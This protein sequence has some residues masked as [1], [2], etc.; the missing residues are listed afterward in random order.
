MVLCIMSVASLEFI[1]NGMLNFAAS[2]VMGGV[3]AAP[4]E[5]SYAAMAYAITAVLALFNHRWCAQQLGSR[6]LVQVS[7]LL[8]AIG[9]VQ[10]AVANTPMAFI[11]GRAL[12]G[13]GGA[14]FF[15][16][17]R[18][19]V[20]T[21]DAKKRLIALLFFGYS[22][23]LGSALGPWLGSLLLLHADWRWIF[24]GILPWIAVAALASSRLHNEPEPVTPARHPEPRAFLWLV[25][26]V[27]ALQFMIQQTPYDF[28]SRP[29]VLLGCLVLLLVCGLAFMLHQH[30]RS[31]DALLWRQLAQRRYLFG[32][33]FYFV[34][35]CLIAANNY[36]MPIMVQQAI[37]FDIPTTGVLLSVSYLAGIVFASIYARLLLSPRKPGLREAMVVGTIMLSGYGYL[38][39]GLN[40]EASFAQIAGIL[41]LN[42]GFLSVFIAAVAQG[43]FQQVEPTAFSHAYL[44]KNIVRQIAISSAVAL[45][46]VFLQA[47]NA[48]HY[49]RLGE[50]FS[51]NGPWL[52]DALA[53]TRQALPQLDL[54]QALGVLGNLLTSQSMLLSCLDFFRLETWVGFALA[55]WIWQQ[56]TFR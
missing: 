42:G 1:Q 28:F 27:F 20:N 26:L 25:A 32:L 8:F 16:A 44:T 23:M 4:E 36:I 31:G 53:Q 6:G 34:C 19:Q 3:G 11:F 35:Y 47:R 17:A 52:S 37:G 56:K 49:Q 22:L 51:W 13:L 33:V 24:W 10:C 38:M 45:S 21:F 39:S 15:T 9:A 46:T 14:T 18:V 41:L 2:S 50:R 5:F 43:T 55:V 7:L 48:V 30:G 40:A 29:L 54:N 12:Q